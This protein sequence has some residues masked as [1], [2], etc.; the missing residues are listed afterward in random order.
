MEKCTK[1]NIN[2]D[3]KKLYHS[4]LSKGTH[5]KS[6][7]GSTLPTNSDRKKNNENLISVGT[8]LEYNTTGFKVVPLGADSKTPAVKST[9]E[10]Y[11]SPRYWTPEKI[12]QEW[13]KFNNVATNFGKTHIKNE[14][15]EDLYL[16]VLDIDSDVVLRILFDKLNGLRSITYVTK[17]K[18]D[19]GYYVY[20]LS[21]KQNPPIASGKCLRGYEFE[22]KTDNTLGLCTL[23]PSRHRDDPNFRY[24]C[25]GKEDKIIIDDTLYGRILDLLAK[26][27]LVQS[28]LSG[29]NEDGGKTRKSDLDSVYKILRDDKIEQLASDIKESYQ[30]GSRHDLVFG[31]SGLLFKNKISLPSAKRLISLL[32]DFTH[33]E[34]KGSRHV[35]LSDTYSKGLDGQEIKGATQLQEVLF[36]IHGSHVAGKILGKISQVLQIDASINGNN[37]DEGDAHL[38]STQILIRLARQNTV[39]LFKDQYGVAYG[40]IRVAEHNEILALESTKFEYYLC[41]L[42]Y[43]FTSGDIVGQEALNN[44]KRVLIAQTL[45]DGPTRELNLRVAWGERKGGEIYYDLAETEWK[46]I[47]ITNENWEIVNS[48]SPAMFARFNQKPQVLPNKYPDRIF[49][50]FLDLMHIQDPGHRLLTKV[51][52]ISLLIPEFPHPISITYGEKGGSKSTFCRFVKRL[53]DP[54]KI[55]LLT[56]PQEKEEFVQQLHHN[57]LAVYDNIKQLPPWFSDEVCK[58]ITGVGSSKRRLYSDDEDIIYDYKRCIM[59]SGINN[60]LTEPD[61]LDRSILT[62]F[63]RIPDDQRK[64]ESEVEALFEEMRPKVFAYILDILV[65]TLKIKP[66]IKLSNFHEWQIF[67]FGEKQLQGPWVTSLWNL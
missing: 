47:R 21:S 20:W 63:D 55:E 34:E 58:A 23:P 28:N 54:D 50:D 24:Y 6:S 5:D 25:V 59:I 3:D 38:S 57:Y 2:P 31:L 36:R 39:L 1:N 27:C 7:T 65:K 64:E 49:D 43:D 10:I 4:D 33:D 18:K 32:C 37:N 60:S 53:V 17:T 48:G 52:I 29:K 67:Q 30:R 45:F 66:S 42:Y 62:Q 14:N 15:G 19:C 16:N 22:I 9:N 56:T 13:H 44:A 40:R 11:D 51:W 35:T 26:E 8:L 46:C 61:A 12:E 41:K